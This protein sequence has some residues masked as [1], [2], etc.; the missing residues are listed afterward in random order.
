MNGRLLGQRARRLDWPAM[1]AILLLLAAGVAFIYSAGW[2]GEDAPSTGFHRRQIGWCA[3][4][5]AVFFTAALTDYRRVGAQA[6]GLYAVGL[7][8]LVA[9]LF[10]GVKVYG[11]RRWLDFFGQ[12]VQPSEF[13]KL[14]TILALA[15]YLAAPATDP[16]SRETLIVAALLAGAPFLLI[17][18]EPD[19][20][21]AATLLPVT[22]L[23]LLAAGVPAR[24]LGAIALGGL[25]LLPLGWLA[26]GDYQRSRILVFL[27]PGR[28]PLGAGW[29][30]I[31]SGI[32]VGSGGLWGKGWLRGTQNV[33]G[34]LPRTVAPTDFIFS[35]IAEE[36]GFA[37]SLALLALYAIVLAGGVRAALR[38]RDPF[39][40]LLAAGLTALLFVHVFVNIAM[41]I[42]LAP[43][44][45][46][47]LP[48]VSYGGSFMA[49]ALLALGWIQSVF[50][51][52]RVE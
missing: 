10:L 25:A 22:A 5:L 34:F 37:G 52:R 45:G 21:S 32:A 17:A 44:T 23:M 3:V 31:Q 40:R 30:S 47:P 38:A 42:G 39:G 1:M 4:G 33:L 11:A 15:R 26:L 18:A 46:L 8:T 50:V 14:A 2:R 19:L 7:A 28:D 35:V 9:V 27:D 48:L 41:T 16:R 12:R 29:N 20:G 6:Y 51:R 24:T 49:A 36:K 43:V 13:A